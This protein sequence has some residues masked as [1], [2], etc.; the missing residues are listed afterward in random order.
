MKAVSRRIDRALARHVPEQRIFLRSEN[1]T[2]YMRLSPTVQVSAGLTCAGVLVWCLVATISFVLTQME[3]DRSED[4]IALLRHTYEERLALMTD[5]RDVQLERADAARQRFHQAMKQVAAQQSELLDASMDERALALT[6]DAVRSKL[7]DA[8]RVRDHALA[9]NE[10]L[11]SRLTDL[12]IAVASHEG[13]E[14]DLSDTL[15]TVTTAL[16]RVAQKR[17]AA[18]QSVSELSH[19]LLSLQDRMKIDAQRKDR[20]LSRL[21]EAVEISLGTFEGLIKKTGMD[22]EALTTSIRQNYS[23]EGGPFIPVATAISYDNDPQSARITALMQDLERINLLRIA[24]AKIPFAKPVKSAHRFTS[25]FGSRRDPKNRRLRQHN[26]IDLAA[27]RGTPILATAD[28]VVTFASRQSGYGKLI[29]IRH[30]FGV[31]TVYA[32]L[33]AIRVKVGERVAQGD[34]IGDMGNTGRSTG[35]HLHYEI[36]LNGRPVNPMTYLKAAKDVL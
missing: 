36:R 10:L 11:T 25:G 5:A 29:K 13:S 16:T 17:E 8:I 23:G 34:R 20:M 18:E 3:Q 15:T 26:G 27:S 19:E 33:N 24:A 7:G 6:L 22:A 12:R 2:S 31:E 14:T 30:A 32:H 4:Q 35:T 9:D 28:G 21:E 1:K